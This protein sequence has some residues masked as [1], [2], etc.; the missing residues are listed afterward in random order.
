[1]VV[2]NLD[3]IYVEKTRAD[4]IVVAK[5]VFVIR[6]HSSFSSCLRHSMR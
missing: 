4:M 2:E 3:Q 6:V 5:V 1:M